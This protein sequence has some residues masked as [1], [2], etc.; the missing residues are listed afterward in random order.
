MSFVVN[1]TLH[2]AGIALR[3]KI[4]GEERVRRALESEDDLIEY[5]HLLGHECAYA[6]VW[7][8]AGLTPKTRSLVAFAMLAALTPRGETLKVHIRGAVRNGATRAEVRQV[9]ATIS[10]YLGAGIGTDAI[11]SAR[12]EFAAMEHE[13]MPVSATASAVDD[14]RIEA[15][16]TVAKRGKVMRERLFGVETPAVVDDGDAGFAYEGLKTDYYFGVLWSDD[17]LP[18][19]LRVLVVIGILCASN[20]LAQ[21]KVYLRA[22]QRLGCN[23][24][25]IKEVFLTACIYCGAPACEDGLAAAREIFPA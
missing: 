4:L 11:K 1:D 25:E 18:P 2:R 15:V 14:T 10:F 12:E 20:R 17:A 3:S 23:H 9:L 24:G 16:D 6:Q 7:S 8:R 22:A 13:S 5:H 21:L 19:A